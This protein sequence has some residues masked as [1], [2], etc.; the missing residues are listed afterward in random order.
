MKARGQQFNDRI[1][2]VTGA[3][4]GL[5]AAIA[6]ALVR[7]GC[8][9]VVVGRR[10]AKLEETAKSTIDP[11]R[12]HVFAQ[13]LTADGAV[14]AL[15]SYCKDRFGKLDILVNNMAVG[16]GGD[17]AEASVDEIR[18]A[19]NT[20]LLAPMLLAHAALPHLELLVNVNS[21]SGLLPLPGQAV[22]AATKFGM[23]GFTEALQAEL[24]KSR[25][26]ILSIYPGAIDS[27]MN[28]KELRAR[29]AAKNLDLPPVTSSDGAASQ[30]IRAIRDVDCKAAVVGSRPE[31]AIG[32]LARRRSPII[33][34]FLAAMRAPVQILM[35]ESIRMVRERRAESAPPKQLEHA[36][37][38]AATKAS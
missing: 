37:D 16:H 9:V 21:L 24:A 2:V 18:E 31:R 34:A 29:L 35:N 8:Q 11:S 20:N 12:V 36:P 15:L 3:G 1:A 32:W 7:E 30:V 17:F 19:V 26:R 25:V 14:D 38:V 4:T 28:S 10:R 5:G 27:E 13:D 6:R 33:N 23:R 22:Y